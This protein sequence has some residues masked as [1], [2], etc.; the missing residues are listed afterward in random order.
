M[1]VLKC[2]NYS[3]VSSTF[4]NQNYDILKKPFT[5]IFNSNMDNLFNVLHS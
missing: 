3:K 4:E 1:G 5:S 2:D